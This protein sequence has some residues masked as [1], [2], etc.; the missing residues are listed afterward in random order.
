M[1]RILL[2]LLATV[3]LLA[4]CGEAAPA[5]NES[6]AEN[7]LESSVAESSTE[8]SAGGDTIPPAFVNAKNGKLPSVSHDAGSAVDLLE[9]VEAMDNVTAAEDLQIAIT[10][11]GGY[12][13]DIPGTYTVTVA[14][15]D[16]AGNKAEA[17]VEV[18]VRPVYEKITLTLGGEIPYRLNDT[19][20]LV[21]TSSGTSTG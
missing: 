1:K 3:L 2:L 9:G 4:S 18:T 8:E 20:A 19:S 5:P 17:T 10:N 14:V 15:T 21:Y 11:E 13:P 7:S 6:S 12:D 16:E